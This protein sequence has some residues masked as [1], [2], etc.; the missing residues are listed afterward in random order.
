MRSDWRHSVNRGTCVAVS[1]V[2]AQLIAAGSASAAGSGYGGKT[3]AGSGV[4]GGFSNIVTVRS[5][6]RKGGHFSVR[7]SGGTVSVSAPAGSYGSLCQVVVTKGSRKTVTADLPKSLKGSDV[8]ASFGVELRSGAKTISTK[9]KIK[10]S[11]SASKI[12]EGDE[13]VIYSAKTHK[14]QVVTDV[15]VSKGKV[16]LY[17]T[18][19]ESI[20]IIKPK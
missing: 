16:V 5:I 1:L 7:T 12:G 10:V 2:A 6:C 8:L 18:V 14:F 13:V 4:P 19:G 20:A 11:F 17:L 9:R 15:T 3:P